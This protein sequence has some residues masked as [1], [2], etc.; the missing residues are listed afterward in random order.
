MTD[1]TDPRA[2]VGMP[3]SDVPH[4]PV[5]Y[6]ENTISFGFHNGVV[7]LTLTTSRDWISEDGTLVSEQVVVAHLRSAVPAAASLR[8]ALDKALLLAAP[9]AGEG[10]AN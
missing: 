2:A 1:D 10:K 3:A 5:L 6:F 7:S 4:A 8:S 9:P